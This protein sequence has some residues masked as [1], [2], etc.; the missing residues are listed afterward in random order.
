MNAGHP[1]EIHDRRANVEP[2]V[3]LD[4]A[5]VEPLYTLVATLQ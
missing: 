2:H 5:V 3:K 1:A 4:E